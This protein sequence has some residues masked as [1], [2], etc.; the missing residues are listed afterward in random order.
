MKEGGQNLLCLGTA[1]VGVRGSLCK[2]RKLAPSGG[3]PGL[4]SL[5][6][7]PRLSVGGLTPPGGLWVPFFNKYLLLTLVSKMGG[8]MMSQNPGEIT[9]CSS[10]LKTAMPCRNKVEE[11]K[12]D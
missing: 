10:R 3:F 9:K 7:P 1:G 6:P 2:V 5:G 12:K 11:D 8:Q 4:L